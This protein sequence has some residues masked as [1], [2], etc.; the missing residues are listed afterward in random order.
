M[1]KYDCMIRILEQ[2]L[3]PA[4]GCTEP[5][6][7]AYAANL[8][9]TALSD[10]PDKVIVTTSGNIVKNVKG[11]VI[12]NSGGLKG[13]KA[14][15]ILGVVAPDSGGELDILEKLSE[16][17]IIKA[18]ELLETDFCE[19]RLEENEGPL[20][21]MVTA[22]KNGHK[23]TAIIKGGHT[24]VILIEKDG[25]ILFK[26]EPKEEAEAGSFDDCL[27]VKDIV[28][29]AKDGDIKGA[30]PF[31]DR[32]IKMNTEISDE[33]MNREYGAAIGRM[34]TEEN[35]D[36][37]RVRA[38][39]K[40]AA[41]ADARM[42]G[43]PMPVIIN[44]GSGNQ[45]IT[46]TVPVV[47]Y[48]K[49]LNASKEKL[50][51]ALIISNLVSVH[52]KRHIGKLSAFCGAVS[53]ASGAG[54]AITFLKGG[55]YEEIAATITSTIANVSG[56][57]CDGAKASCAVKIASALDAAIMADTLTQ[58]EK[59]F[60]EGDGIVSCDV[61][62]TIRN[63]GDVGGKGMRETDIEIIKAMSKPCD[64]QE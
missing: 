15:C 22:E 28:A 31:L 41:G 23:G 26:A 59:A 39:A 30:I 36:D 44:S 58:R 16:Q 62:Q 10:I 24:D 19:T 52:I 55:G 11:V 33:G 8:A 64:K 29:F 49:E 6:A 27:S 34:L 5:A 60:S 17:E 43:S 45:G 56:I 32:Q 12:P 21:I 35:P 3:V 18:N 63:L 46:V 1:E 37:I 40:A 14:S 38:K 54:A 25:E 53:A 13:L 20:Y 61:E 50:Y 7:V 57:F 48:A 4:M 51:R 42:G 2:E 9:K 47:E